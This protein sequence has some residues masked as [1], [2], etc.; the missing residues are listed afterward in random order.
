MRI[1]PLTFKNQVVD[2]QLKDPTKDL[3]R[4]MPIPLTIMEDKNTLFDSRAK[5]VFGHL[6][7]RATKIVAILR[8]QLLVQ[9]YADHALISSSDHK[10]ISKLKGKSKKPR[11]GSS[12]GLFVVLYGLPGLFDVLGLFLGKFDLC[13][14]HPR[15]CNQ[16]VPYLNPHCLSPQ[17]PQII[18][19]QDCNDL[20]ELDFPPVSETFF[21]PI[22]LLADTT[23]QAT[24]LD[25]ETPQAL[26]TPLYYHQK[27]ALTF[28]MQREEGWNL[29]GKDIWKAETNALGRSVYVNTI[30]RQRQHHPP[31]DF[32]GGLLAD[33]PGL[34]KS[35]SI[36]ALI[37]SFEEIREGI[38]LGDACSTTTLLVV[39]KTCRLMIFSTTKTEY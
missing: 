22:D 34:G 29:N 38:K 19:T 26:K 31:T 8:K 23:E 7:S 17:S 15:N 20:L 32:R 5:T 12:L 14:Q 2:L 3:G 1:S 16:N 21:N 37:A 35:L 39:P 27:Q 36:I 24:L 9:I 25:T 18:Y 13:L 4:E 6:D 11:V 10:T 30:T 28:M 33:S